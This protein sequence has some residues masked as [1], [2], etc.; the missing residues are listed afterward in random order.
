MPDSTAL[1]VLIKDGATALFE[2]VRTR[3]AFAGAAAAVDA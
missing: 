2:L 1:D 3:V